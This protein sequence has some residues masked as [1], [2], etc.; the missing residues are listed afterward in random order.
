MI[1]LLFQR[2]VRM[3]LQ[4]RLLLTSEK[5]LNTPYGG[6]GTHI[7]FLRSG[8]DLK[9]YTRVIV[10]IYFQCNIGRTNIKVLCTS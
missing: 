4:S 2:T 8:K 6:T 5:V 7:F 1:F 10:L 3:T 9:K